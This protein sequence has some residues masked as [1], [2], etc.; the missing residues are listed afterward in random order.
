MRCHAYLCRFS[1]LKPRNRL[2]KCVSAKSW[3]RSL[4]S[5]WFTSVIYVVN[6]YFFF[7]FFKEKRLGC[8]NIFL[9]S[10]YFLRT[11]YI[12][13]KKKKKNA[14]PFQQMIHSYLFIKIT[15][16]TMRLFL[17]KFDIF[18]QS[19]LVNEIKHEIIRVLGIGICF[20]LF[21]RFETRGTHWEHVQVWQ[22]LRPRNLSTM[23]SLCLT[24]SW[25]LTRFEIMNTC[26]LISAK[27]REE[28]LLEYR[29]NGNDG[30][31]E[32]FG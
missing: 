9:E 27:T 10:Y 20:N 7:L 28:D 24:M 18:I 16:K 23:T 21:R 4:E 1:R 30:M 8:C 32:M 22:G 29:S 14:N 6:R 3:C 26:Q 17:K 31:V 2:R 12:W 25:T 19:I 5:Y 15:Y 13:E 11:R